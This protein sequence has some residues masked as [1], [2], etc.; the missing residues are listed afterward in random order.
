MTEENG[1]SIIICCYNSQRTIVRTLQH[2]LRQRE[3]EHIRREVIVV[4]NNCNDETVPLVQ[5]F[6]QRHPDLDLTLLHEARSGLLYARNAGVAQARYALIQ[7]CDDDNFLSEDFLA[8]VWNTMQDETVGA[9]GGKGVAMFDEGT[10]VPP[11]FEA[12]APSYACG[13]QGQGDG[14]DALYLYGAGLCIRKNILQRM[15]EQ[16]FNGMLTGRTEGRQ[17]SGDDTELCY[18]VRR[19]GYRLRYVPEAVFG[20]CLSADRLTLDYVGRLYY[21]FGFSLPV[22]DMYARC[23]RNRHVSRWHFFKRKMQSVRD[24]VR[25]RWRGSRTDD[26]D[27]LLRTAQARGKK[28]GY[29]AFGA[30]RLLEQYKAFAALTR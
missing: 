1:I 17:L 10:D 26:F 18:A 20:H 21:G 22:L 9:C 13:E 4:D 8:A 7:F 11:W 2:L 30:G 27:R 28:D 5:A 12:I 19:M 25:L 16:H 15:A 23:L 14:A 24:C 29:A 3:A 6:G